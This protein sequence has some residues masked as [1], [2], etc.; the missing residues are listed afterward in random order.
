MFNFPA[1]RDKIRD[2]EISGLM[3]KILEKGEIRKEWLARVDKIM[4]GFI[5]REVRDSEGGQK[6][7]KEIYDFNAADVDS[8]EIRT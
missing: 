6:D 4:E 3:A 1:I 8:E 5:A 7:S 2:K